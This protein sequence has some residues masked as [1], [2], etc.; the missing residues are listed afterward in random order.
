MRSKQRSTAL[1]QPASESQAPGAETGRS[2][3][4]LLR[5]WNSGTP[6]RISSAARSE[7][8]PERRGTVGTFTI[9]LRPEPGVNAT[10]ALPLALKTLLRAHGLRCTSLRCEPAMLEQPGEARVADKILAHDAQEYGQ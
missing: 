2:T 7:S 8:V 5:K 10:I 1:E 9:T 3:C 6:T 4:S